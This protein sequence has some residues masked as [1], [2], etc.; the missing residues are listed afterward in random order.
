ML[1]EFTPEDIYKW[2]NNSK[3]D[4]KPLGRGSL[5]DRPFNDGGGFRVNYNGD[6]L[7]QYHPSGFHHGGRGYYKISNGKQGTARYNLDGTVL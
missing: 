1:K 6:G 3:Y 4:V 7:F 2:L 5:K